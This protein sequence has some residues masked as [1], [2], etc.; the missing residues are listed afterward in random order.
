M[1]K[2]RLYFILFIGSIT[3]FSCTG[4]RNAINIPPPR[5]YAD[6]Y[7]ADIDSIETY[8]KSHSLKKVLVDGQPDIEISTIPTNNPEALVSIWN[9]TEVPLRFKMVKNDARSSSLVN[10]RT[11]DPVDYK[12]YYLILNEGGGQNPQTIDSTYTTYK[13]WNL[14]GNVFD[15]SNI[16]FW[17][18]FPALSAAETNVISGFRQF[19]P[20]LK[21]AESTTINP[22]NGTVNY[23]NMGVGV[24]FIPSGLGYYNTS[25]AAIPAYSP[26]VFR[27]RL[28]TIHQRDHDGDRIFTK[29]EDINNDG[30]F[31]NDD[32]D[33]DTVPNFLDIDDD[34][35]QYV[36]KNEIRINGAIPSEY[37]LIQDCNGTTTGTK[38]HLDKNCK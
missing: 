34:G 21:T 28:H 14:K 33:G 22:D 15:S 36:T 29:N 12:L 6:L 24:V 10:G 38:K 11:A 1:N 7:I 17:S 27:I 25:T 20:L 18:T 9:N 30:D 3:L 31:F 4:D 16:P 23:N 37:N 19:L 26:L 32:T 13:G 5:S 2:F 35:D 8:L